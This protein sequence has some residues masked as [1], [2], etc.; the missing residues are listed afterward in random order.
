[1]GDTNLK[2]RELQYFRDGKFWDAEKDGEPQV[3]IPEKAGKGLIMTVDVQKYHLWWVTR[4]W[5][6]GGERAECGLESWGNVATFDDLITHIEQA[7]PSGIGV[8][9][10]YTER[11]GEVADF[12]A[13]TGALALKGEENMKGDIYLRDDLDPSEGR[14]ARTSSRQKYQMLTW[15]TDI[16]RAKFLAAMRGE[17]PWQWWVYRMAERE[18]TR[19]VLSTHKQDGEWKRKRGHPAD[20]LFDCEVMQLVMARFDN[21]IQ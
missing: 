10:G 4:W 11:F 16:F 9:I 17:T 15:N 18:Y 21:L 5:V 20:H 13:A 3:T 2:S 8:D 1:V 19:Q 7:Q 6:V 12:C 14:K